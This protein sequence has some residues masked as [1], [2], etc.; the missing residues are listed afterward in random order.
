MDFKK[1][2]HIERLGSTE[3]KGIEIGTV[4][5]FPKIDGTNASLWWD[6]GLQ[7]GSRNRHLTVDTEDNHGFREWAMQQEKFVRFFKDHPDL[8]LFGEWLVPHTLKTYEDTAWHNFYV[9]DVITESDFSYVPYEEYKEMLALYDIQFIPAIC[10]VVNPTKD[11]LIAQL[12]KNGYLVKDGAGPGEGVVIKNYEYRNPFGRSIWAKIVRNEFKTKHWSHNTTE[13]KEKKEVEQEIVDK[14]ITQAL[15]EKEFAKIDAEVGWSSK[16]IPRLLS[17][18]FYCLVKEESWSFV[19]EHKNPTI[20]FK[21]LNTLAI[22][23]IK[24]HKPEIF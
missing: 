7:A 1:Y 24:E 16:L 15:V 6:N 9:F 13:V 18:V 12:D 8:K 2:Q 4:W 17:T 23:K 3:T 11:R 21:R 10:K 19:K 22:Q 5:V 20:D 14:Y